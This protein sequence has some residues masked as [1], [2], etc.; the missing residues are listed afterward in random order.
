[1]VAQG[2]DAPATSYIGTVLGI[3]QLLNSYG[4]DG[5][6]LLQQA[7]V[8]VHTSP[9]FEDRVPSDLLHAALMEHAREHIDPAF[10]L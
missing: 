2:S 9:G 5:Y 7:G 8:D 3:A 10:G 6:G 1:M 4:I